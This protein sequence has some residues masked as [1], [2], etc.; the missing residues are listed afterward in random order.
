M[1]GCE[2]LICIIGP[3]TC[4]KKKTHFQVLTF[5]CS[6]T[7]DP[8]FKYFPCRTTICMNV[9]RRPFFSK[10]NTQSLRLVWNVLSCSQRCKWCSMEVDTLMTAPIHYIAKDN[11][12]IILYSHWFCSLFIWKKI[13]TSSSMCKSDSSKH[14]NLNLLW[15]LP[16][17]TQINREQI[18]PFI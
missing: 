4:V 12:F 11:I 16:P 15:Y 3:W 2:N 13:Y 5:T 14:I 1:K 9:N 10:S 6:R 8:Y 17:P 7:K 18:P